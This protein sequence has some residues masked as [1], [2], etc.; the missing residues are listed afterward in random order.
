[1][2]KRSR[3]GGEKLESRYSE[4]EYLIR[5]C[6]NIRIFD[7]YDIEVKDIVPLRNVYVL[8]TDNGTKILK[9]LSYFV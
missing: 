2:V 3:R 6:L 9:K 5:Y 8:Y 4:N 7:E 1:M